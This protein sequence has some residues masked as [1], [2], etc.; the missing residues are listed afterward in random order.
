MTTPFFAE[1][2]KV[3]PTAFTVT[4]GTTGIFV[5]F[6]V[7]VGVAETVGFGVAVG[8]GLGVTEGVGVGVT[9]GAA[10]IVIVVWTVFD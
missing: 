3:R 5:G 10:L 9:T 1:M 7:G 8:V 4:V 6:G 2:V